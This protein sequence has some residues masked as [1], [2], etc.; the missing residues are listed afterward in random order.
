MHTAYTSP[1]YQNFSFADAKYS[2][3]HNDA[4]EL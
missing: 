2:D 1:T 4:P 3:T